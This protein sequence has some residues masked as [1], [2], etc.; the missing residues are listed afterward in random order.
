MCVD[1][2]SAN[3]LVDLVFKETKPRLDHRQNE[4]SR[5]EAKEELDNRRGKNRRVTE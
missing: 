1:S 4:V 5:A 3:R 2:K